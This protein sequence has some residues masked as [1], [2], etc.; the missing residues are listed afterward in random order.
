MSQVIVA[1]YHPL[2]LKGICEAI[3]EELPTAQI[4][5]TATDVKSFISLLKLHKP[6]IAVVEVSVT[7]KSDMDLMDEI[8]RVQPNI[9]MQFVSVH[10]FDQGV[11]DYLI[12]KAK[13]R[14]HQNS[15]GCY[16]PK[17]QKGTHYENSLAENFS[18]YNVSK[19]EENI[20]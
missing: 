13:K 2:V 15:I 7:W 3:T 5:A 16:T 6:E 8:Y 9:K 1:A 20:F 10:P 12:S 11:Q 19:V 4:V 18:G 17:Y 14:Y